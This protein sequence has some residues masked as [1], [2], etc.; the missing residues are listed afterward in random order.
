MLLSLKSNAI[1]NKTSDVVSINLTPRVCMLLSPTLCIL[2]G[3][4]PATTEAGSGRAFRQRACGH[5]R[6]KPRRHTDRRLLRKGG[7]DHQ[8]P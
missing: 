4:I 2:P 6:I 7:P 5:V 3:P 8:N 1:K